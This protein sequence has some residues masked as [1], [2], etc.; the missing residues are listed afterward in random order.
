MSARSQARA[1]REP[2]APRPAPVAER[3]AWTSPALIAVAL[4]AAVSTLISVTFRID[5]PDLWQHLAVGR[6]VWTRHALPLV[7]QWTWPSWGQPDVNP[8]WGFEVLLWPFWDRGGLIGLFLW[9]WITTLAAFGF[10]WAAARQSPI[11]GVPG[12]TGLVPAFVIAFCALT[13]RQRSDLRPETLSAVLFAA[14]LWI[15]ETR[16]SAAGGETGGAQS[17]PAPD[18][19]L[20]LIPIQWIWAN[21]HLTAYLGVCLIGLYLL[22]DLFARRPAKRLAGVLAASVV[23]SFVNPFGWKALAQPFE[24]FLFWRHEPVFQNIPELAPTPLRYN[25]SNGLPFLFVGWPILALWRAA[26]RRGDRV[27]IV[28]CVVFTLQAI[29]SRRFAGFYVLAATPF[30]S[31]DLTD[32]FALRFVPRLPLAVRAAAVSAACLLVGAVEWRRWEF[33]IAIALDDASFPMR[34]CD[35]MAANGVRGRGMNQFG[36][37]GWQ[38]Y[39]FWPDRSRLPFI[40]IH[41]TGTR[42]D[43]DLYA[44]AQVSPEAWKQLDE[45]HRFDYALLARIQFSGDRLLDAL[46]SD[47]TFALVFKDDAAAL[48]V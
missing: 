18:R 1:R 44:F 11:R 19:S 29:L 26:R 28:L 35:F 4:A 7:H 37:S 34:A 15:L 20:A 14:M 16:R 36:I 23:I 31:R 39:R 33:P 6:F 2:P 30:V 46:D 32:L 41:Q 21:T 38:V 12:A 25:W 48:Y 22:E 47:S 5:D 8:S 10:A 42:E 43:R 17:G 40:D 9:R 3:L 45:R 27:E 13:Y 24:Y